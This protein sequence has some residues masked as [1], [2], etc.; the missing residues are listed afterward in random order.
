V[1]TVDV[2]RLDLVYNP[3][4][5]ILLGISVP[6]PETIARTI[7]RTRNLDG[8]IRLLSLQLEIYNTKVPVKDIGAFVGKASGT[9]YQPFDYAPMRWSAENRELSF[10]GIDPH[11]KGELARDMPIAVKL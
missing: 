4:G 7:A 10:Q 8:A 11:G 1:T 6:A 5:K 9:L 2:L 3:F